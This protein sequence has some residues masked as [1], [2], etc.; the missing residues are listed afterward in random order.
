MKNKREGIVKK[1]G[2]E[3]G[4]FLY[5]RGKLLVAKVS[6]KKVERE[7]KTTIRIGQVHFRKCVNKNQ[8]MTAK[9]HIFE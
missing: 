4:K 7:V 2:K 6:V 8:N 5:G 1:K 9:E 3:E